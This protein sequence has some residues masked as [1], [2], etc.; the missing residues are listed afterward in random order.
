MSTIVTRLASSARPSFYSAPS[1][2][3]IRHLHVVLNS[4][5]STSARTIIAKTTVLFGLRAIALPRVGFVWLLTGNSHLDT[6][7]ILGIPN[8]VLFSH[9]SRRH[10]PRQDPSSPL[11]GKDKSSYSGL[12]PTPALH[13]LTGIRHL[14]IQ[15]IKHTLDSDVAVTS[16]LG[17]EIRHML[18]RQ[19]TRTLDPDASALAPKMPINQPG[20]PRRL[21]S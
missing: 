15:A 1:C 9:P 8:R 19:A 16:P 20:Q 7:G 18:L 17:L 4:T 14:F 10:L 6:V 13:S 2:P 3:A 12:V 21:E 11:R 5:A